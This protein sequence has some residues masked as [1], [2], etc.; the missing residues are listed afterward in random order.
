MAK[1]GTER[2]IAVARLRSLELVDPVAERARDVCTTML[3][4]LDAATELQTRLEPMADRLDD[5][6]RRDAAVPPA[7]RARVLELYALATRSADATA[8]SIEPCT[9]AMDTLRTQVLG[10]NENR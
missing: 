6:V 5:Y 1:R 9:R 10:R 7:E 2:R 3:E 8:A 4:S